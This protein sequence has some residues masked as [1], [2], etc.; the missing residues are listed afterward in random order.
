MVFYFEFYSSHYFNKNILITT[1]KNVYKRE[2]SFSGN[3]SISSLNKSKK[4]HIINAY[5]LALFLLLVFIRGPPWFLSEKR[6]EL[7]YEE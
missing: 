3:R 7:R 6:K 4:I 5:K 1:Q 2:L